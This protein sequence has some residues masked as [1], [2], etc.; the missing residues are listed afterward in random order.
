MAPKYD[1]NEYAALSVEYSVF[2]NMLCYNA[3]VPRYLPII[4]RQALP[5]RLSGTAEECAH[6][7]DDASDEPSPRYGQRAR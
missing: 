3:F 5:Q 6:V 4:T 7:G 1:G 2:V